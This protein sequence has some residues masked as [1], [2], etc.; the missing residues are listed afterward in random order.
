PETEFTGKL[1][2]HD[3]WSRRALRHSGI[4]VVALPEEKAEAA[5]AALRRDPDIEFA[6]RDY[7]ADAAYVPVDPYILSGSEWHLEQIQAPQAWNFTIGRP[8]SVVAVLDSG[9]DITHPD[10][11]TQ[12]LPGYD[13]VFNDADPADDFG[14][15][16]AVCG[17][18]VAA[19][20]N[21]KG[22]A[23]VA[24]GCRVL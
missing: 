12:L 10:L 4:R 11:A 15:G 2:N 1:R 7:V 3:A 16:T 23:G 9:V 13:F 14:H 5:L 20:N 22:V 19:G 21:G 18:V 24:F 17:T 8:N 6:E